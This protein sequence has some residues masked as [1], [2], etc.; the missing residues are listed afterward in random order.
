MNLFSG[1]MIPA[2][3]M[4]WWWRWV[5]YIN[6]VAWSLYALL[7][8]QLGTVQAPVDDFGAGT[9]TVA[10]FME[11]RFGYSYSMVGPIVAILAG[12]VLFFRGVSI[13]ALTRINYQK[14]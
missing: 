12:F 1:F 10:L 6:P 9:T 3:S 14:R 13:V 4:G 11:E 7:S 2:A 5:T 8:S